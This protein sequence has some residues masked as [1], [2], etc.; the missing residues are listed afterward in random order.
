MSTKATPATAVDPRTQDTSDLWRRAVV[1][2]LQGDSPL[3]AAVWNEPVDILRVLTSLVNT[4]ATTLC[5]ETQRFRLKG[6]SAGQ[7]GPASLSLTLGEVEQAFELEAERLDYVPHPKSAAHSAF[8][9]SLTA[10]NGGSTQRRVVLAHDN[11]LV[12]PMLTIMGYSNDPD[13]LGGAFARGEVNREGYGPDDPAESLLPAEE[14]D[15]IAAAFEAH[16][17]GRTGTLDQS[18]V[19]VIAWAALE[20]GLQPTLE[21]IRRYAGGGSNTTIH[22]RLKDFY[23]R[24]VKERL[25]GTQVSP[26]LKKLWSQLQA[27]AA[28]EVDEK[29]TPQREALQLAEQGVAEERIRL[30]DAQEAL[31]NERAALQTADQAR[32]TFLASLEARLTLATEQLSAAN[33]TIAGDADQ[34]AEYRTELRQAREQVA[35]GEAKLA[36]RDAHL[37]TT[38]EQLAAVSSKLADSLRQIESSQSKVVE[39]T[40]HAQA[41]TKDLDQLDRSSRKTIDALQARAAHAEATLASER[42]AAAAQTARADTLQRDFNVL[43]ERVGALTAKHAQLQTD[44]QRATDMAETVPALH[45]QLSEA[46]VELR[47]VSEERDRLVES[48]IKKRADHT[49]T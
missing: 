2:V 15:P 24:L 42:S 43:T 21:L 37:A 8:V 25:K 49:K 30:R 45:A 33:H 12:I 7:H 18:D 9:L 22:P 16:R 41:L 46:R 29:M 38:K 3:E 39:A 14:D 11:G 31:A 34:L 23:G 26:V 6:V 10:V 19:D 48:R 1:R 36:S 28:K 13:T 40:A 47:L 44:L 17:Q 35:A 27:S 5:A 32:Q 4:H 20:A